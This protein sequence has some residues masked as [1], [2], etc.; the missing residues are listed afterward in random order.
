[1]A[2]PPTDW[3]DFEPEE[4]DVGAPATSL[5]FERWFRNAPRIQDAALDT[6]VTTDGV[7]WVSDRMVAASVGAVGVYG[8]FRYASGTVTA[9]DTSAGSNLQ[10]SSA[11][12]GALGGNPSGTWQC[13]GA[14]V[15]GVGADAVTLWRRIA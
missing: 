8:M 3:G 1:M 12:A 7:D 4:Y 9:G 11:A 2:F 13:L 5:H 14:A 10:Y 15:G 6:T